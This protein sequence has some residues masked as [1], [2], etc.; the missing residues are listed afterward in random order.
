VPVRLGVIVG[1][2][3]LGTTHR[4]A[5]QD[6]NPDVIRGRVIRMD[7]TP[8]VGAVVKVTSNLNQVTRT[9]R[10]DSS[11]RYSLIV[12]NGG[13]DY[14]VNVTAIGFTPFEGRV[15][16]EGD[17]EIL[18]LDVTMRPSVQALDAARIVES[19]RPRPEMIATDVGGASNPTNQ[20]VLPPN[21]QGDLLAMVSLVPGFMSLYGPD[22]TVTGFSA[23]GL[24]ANQNNVTMNGMTVSANSIPK[25]AN[26]FTRV[27]TTTADA[28][29]GGFSGAQ[30]SMTPFG[31]SPFA[32]HSVRIGID[33]P[34]LQWTDP[35]AQSLNSQFR[36]ISLSGNS[37][38]EV[39]PEKSLYNFSWQLGRRMSPL[40]TLLSADSA[41]LV[42]QGLSP[43]SVRRFEQILRGLGV[44]FSA[45]GVPGNR[46]SDNASL[47]GRFDL[48]S[49]TGGAAYNGSL[50][51]SYN[52]SG[53]ASF[54]PHSLPSYGGSNGSWR[55]NP[56]VYGSMN[57]GSTFLNELRIGMDASNNS[58]QPYVSLP[59]GSVL[60]TSADIDGGTNVQNLQFGSGSSLSRSST[61]GSAQ[62]TDNLS[63]FSNDSK[64]RLKLSADPRYEW[65]DQLEQAN[66]RGTFT[67]NSLAD[68]EAGRPA[69]FVRRLAAQQ[70]SGSLLG[71]SI[72]LMDTWRKT[73]A[74][75]FQYGL[76]YDQYHFLTKPEYNPD[77]DRLF[78]LRTDR[79]PD[80]G[81]LSPR[82][83]GSWNFGKAPASANTVFGP[84][85][86]GTL[87]GT[88]GRYWS[89]LGATT[90][91]DAVDNTGL[92]TGAQQI[93]CIG[94]AVPVPNWAGYFANPSAIP[95]ACADGSAGSA[96]AVTQPR[97][98]TYDP[99][100]EPP[101][102][103]RGNLRYAGYLT[104]KFRVTAEVV[105]SLNE[106]LSASVDRNFDPT[107]RFALPSE[108]GRPVYADPS[109]IVATSGAVSLLASRRSS[110]F[111]QVMANQADGQSRSQQLT[112]S[113]APAN[114]II[115]FSVSTCPINWN[116]SYTLQRIDDRVR[117]YGGSTAANP[118]DFAWGRS[119]GDV[120]HQINLNMNKGLTSTLSLNVSAIVRSGAPF[121]PSVS[122]DVNG[123]GSFNDRAFVFNPAASADTSVATGL[124]S[125]LA[126]APSAVRVCLQNQ[127]GRVAN[128]NSCEGPWTVSN[129]TARFNYRPW[130]EGTASRMT[131][132]LTFSNPLTGIDA[133]VH[134]GNLVGW[135]QPAFPDATL[136]YVRGFD[137]VSRA[138]K[139]EVNQRFGE[140]RAARSI[141]TAPFQATLEMR[142]SLGPSNDVNMGKM[143]M[144]QLMPL[145]K[146]AMEERAIKARFA[147][148]SA[149]LFMALIQQKDSLGLSKEQVDSITKVSARLGRVADSLWTPIAAWLAKQPRSGNEREIGHRLNDGQRA[150]AIPQCDALD[151][152]RVLLTPAQIKRVK[153]PLS[154]QLDE[155]YIK[156]TRKQANGPIM[157]FFGGGG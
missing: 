70:R 55:L 53:A 16:R 37:N 94:S 130:L 66:T 79:V 125:L 21:L 38:G 26:V 25:D 74:L 150:M 57:I 32:Y 115:C 152:V 64:H 27:T 65:Y 135:G 132:T 139:Y 69:A 108:G 131:F 109:A 61:T 11:G 4:L 133:L 124:R 90:L 111:A 80:A 104:G 106:H 72:S 6:A 50:N 137:P 136:L 13:G 62:L 141:P 128:R 149:T 155:N 122:G 58:G 67:Y 1:L 102:S 43:D 114:N 157:I 44:P 119:S 8:I 93:T 48:N 71:G 23:L 127:L 110:V 142:V 18:R 31:G 118:L 59:Q 129:L 134:R 107:A 29:R 46:V 123:D 88:V 12:Q 40:N 82:F 78:G 47:L 153:P 19:R 101:S 121:T 99:R 105:Y 85:V 52:R 140:T 156:A 73:N 24:S 63:W 96:F 33:D 49:T 51:A 28:S 86:L 144:R 126:N 147:G 151:A 84:G 68:L 34:A 7:S 83:G 77:V 60:V 39:V 120:R 89:T 98:S 145:G 76:R 91:S 92:A 42:R 143:T 22:G 30:V 117:G 17:E 5:A 97:V 87:S 100:Y 81:G 95:G 56:Q 9:G 45:A 154:F 75:Q 103:W 36:N 146:P 2:L 138:F 116:V 14:T 15:R 10:T 3:A 54:G 35:A 148:Q 112:L 41:G 113:L 20:G